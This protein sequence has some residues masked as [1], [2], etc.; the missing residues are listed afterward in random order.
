ILTLLAP[1]G[2][3]SQDAQSHIDPQRGDSAAAAFA[4][5][6]HEAASTDD[7]HQDTQRVSLSYLDVTV[8]GEAQASLL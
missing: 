1:K 5:A 3:L 8:N 2:A 7:T 6:L 4:R